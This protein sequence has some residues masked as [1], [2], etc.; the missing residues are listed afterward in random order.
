MTAFPR[1]ILLAMLLL[2]CAPDGA[3]E[4]EQVGQPSTLQE[5]DRLIIEDPDDPANYALRARL[6][7]A[8]DSVSAAMNDWKRAIA[9]DSASAQWR[10]A[11]GDLYYRKIDLPNAEAQFTKAIQ[12][13][14]EK[15]EARLKLAELRMVKGDLTEAMQLANEALRIDQQ[16]ARAYFLKGWIHREAGDTALAISSYRT[17]VE[18]DRD[19]YEAYIALGILHAA[20]RDPLAMEYYDAAVELRPESVEAWYDRGMCAQEMGL[21]SIALACYARI[22]TIDP[23]NAT[24]WYNTGYVLLEHL[25]DL[26]KARLEFS[27]AIALLPTYAHAYYNRGLTFELENELDSALLDYKRALAIKP[28]LD[29]AAEGLGRLQ[30]KGLKVR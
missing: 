6:H 11:L 17:A 29:L 7:E 8:M 3:K 9:L 28:D 21:D 18:R 15:N 16:N 25:N 26:P 14:P 5:V 1:P 24:A 10:I 30:A 12:L 4:A 2:S 19:F 20:M 22:K 13:E 27:H 23:R